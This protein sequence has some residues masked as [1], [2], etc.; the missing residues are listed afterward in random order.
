MKLNQFTDLGIRALIYL[1]QPSSEV[2]ITIEK[3]ANELQVSRNHLVKVIHFM[4][5]KGWLITSRGKGGGVKLT[6]SL[7][8]YYIGDVI[9]TLEEY[10]SPSPHLINCHSPECILQEFCGLPNLL[11]KALFQFYS[12][13]N[14]Y[15]LQDVAYNQSGLMLLK[16]NLAIDV[17]TI[18]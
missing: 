16:Q 10:N 11:S 12:L 13:L 5:K 1:A 18:D 3:M 7:N 2:T 14:Q 4:G 8:Q 17:V 15:T 6:N 9:R